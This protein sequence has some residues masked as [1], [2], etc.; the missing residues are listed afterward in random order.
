M[1]PKFYKITLLILIILLPILCF[2]IVNTMVSLKYETINP[3]DC[4][5]QVSKINLCNSLKRIKI[6][7]AIDFVIIIIFINFRKYLVKNV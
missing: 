2:G 5:S 3:T 1:T 4:V 6:Y 7:A